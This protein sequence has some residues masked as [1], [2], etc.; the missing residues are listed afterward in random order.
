MQP[1]DKSFQFVAFDRRFIHS[2]RDGR[3]ELP[4]RHP[5]ERIELLDQCSNQIIPI[6]NLLQTLPSC[7][8]VPNCLKRS[9]QRC[10]HSRSRRL[11]RRQ[12]GEKKNLRSQTGATRGQIFLNRTSG[13]EGTARPIL[14]AAFG[15]SANFASSVVS[16]KEMVRS[17][18]Q[19]EGLTMT[20]VQ[21]RTTSRLPCAGKKTNRAAE[22]AIK[23]CCT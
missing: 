8:G 1:V 17:P 5:D 6:H 4:C 22:A 15:I 3:L 7:A 13:R 14:A 9:E 12:G 18:S 16:G 2:I 10:R 23:R 21:N 20:P 11:H 19:S